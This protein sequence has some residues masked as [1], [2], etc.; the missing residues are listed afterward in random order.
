MVTADHPEHAKGR[1]KAVFSQALTKKTAEERQG[2]LAEACGDD[3][4]LRKLVVSLLA[5]HEQA[6]DFLDRSVMGDETD[7]LSERPGTVIGQ[8]RLVEKLGEGG[9][10]VV[11]LAEQQEPVRRQVALKIIK[12]GMDTR[13]VIAR[14]EAERQALALM[15]HPNIAR[16]Y[17]AGATETGRPYFVMELVQGVPIT[18]YC[19]AQRLHTS[20]RLDLFL[21]VCRAVQHAH[22]KGIIHRDL[23]PSNI[24]VTLQDGEATPKV[25]DF[26][27]AKSTQIRLTAKTQ[28][29]Q[30]DLTLGTPAYMSPEQV[31]LAEADVDT[32]SDIYSLG[33]IL[34]ELLTGLLPSS[35]EEL[36][37]AA[38]EEARRM[39]REQEPKKPSTRL[40]ALGL[41]TTEVARL[42]GVEPR[43]LRRLLRGDLD[44]ITLKALAKERA[45]RYAT[46]SELVA[47]I[48]RHLNHEPVL[49]TPPSVTYQLGKFLRK[50]RGPAIA[51][52]SLALALL[53][54]FA[55][56]LVMY[57]RAKQSEKEARDSAQLAED[58]STQ[59]TEALIRTRALGL[60]SAAAE[61]VSKDPMLSLLLAL[62]AVKLE[63]RS[64][65]LSQVYRAMA[66][67]H[68]RTV[69]EGHEDEV[70]SAVYS[71]QGDLILTASKD[72]T[73]RVWNRRGQELLVLSG[74]GGP[75]VDAQ[76]SPA[77]E[78]MLILTVSEDFTARLWDMEGNQIAALR[79]HEGPITDAAFSPQGDLVLTGSQDAAA[80]LWNVEGDPI[81]TFR[82]SDWVPSVAFSPQGDLILTACGRGTIPSKS[83]TAHLW[84]R[85]GQ[86]LAVLEGH[87]DSIF[88]AVF[89]PS[90]ERI[91]TVSG[92][93]TAR[94]WA[95]DGTRLA[96]CRGHVDNLG[97]RPCFSPDGRFVLTASW[98][99]TARLWDART[100]TQLRVF[101]GHGGGVIM[102]RFSPAGDRVLTASADQ[103]ARLFDLDGN[104][105]ALLAGHNSF[106]S[107]AVFSPSGDEI[108]TASGDGTARL[109]DATTKEIPRFQGH[110]SGLFGGALSP[111]GNCI[112]TASGD[113][114]VRIWS[115]AGGAPTVCHGHDSFVEDVAFSPDGDSLLSGSG[116]LTARLW[117]LGGRE[118]A[119]FR[120][121]EDELSAVGFSH[122]GDRVLTGSYDGTVRFWNLRGEQLGLLRFP[123]VKILSAVFAP[124]DDRVLMGMSDGTAQLWNLE[125]NKLNAWRG[126]AGWVRSA[127]FSPSEDQILTAGD[128]GT[129]RLWDR[130]GREI[131]ALRGHRGI[132]FS[133]V[134]SSD[135]DR[136]LTASWDRTARLWPA[137]PAALLQ[138]ARQRLSDREFSSA[139]RGRY[140]DVLVPR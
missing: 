4:Q 84:R 78:P 120:G 69:L 36:R 93:R 51:A 18:E 5:A 31:G 19:D 110:S 57:S 6:G 71:P 105:L 133:A 25:I 75:V 137:E 136:V 85:S 138:L 8:Y 95:C 30:Q 89:S 130:A 32:R 62:E 90:G 109:W 15:D 34:Y 9:F 92:D 83:S 68:E 58:R 134:F 41:K 131:A 122:E 37:H 38:I 97:A 125:G 111:R 46:V 129:A 54:G 29:T 80:R 49:A 50:Y 10:G 44:L 48:A 112:A 40:A 116:D 139:E 35:S 73:A 117:D 87:E 106:V 91:L 72:G 86:Q 27:I 107:T 12:L 42:R 114:T 81:Q 59:L 67:L 28:L 14:F 118:L 56:T 101:R 3:D 99:G 55:G 53:G 121:H 102:V 43:V 20:Q 70:T 60:A 103:T 13:Q 113:G 26:G 123:G 1:I 115:L 63:R 74:H 140:R 98:D 124:G 104:E 47:D 132:V 7:P 94:L 23:K 65:T 21:E 33:V 52:A 77:G 66:D 64:E 100:G 128:D 17:E 11:Y 119:I 135:G 82:H 127:V 16:V 79:G 88:W 39:I 76:F 126:H 96:V 45:R 22:Q 61:A 108:L 2:Y 24:V